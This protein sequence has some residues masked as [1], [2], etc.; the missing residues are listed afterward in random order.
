[1]K[2]RPNYPKGHSQLIQG[3][4]KSFG[5]EFK[6]DMD[7]IQRC[8]N[9]VEKEITLAKSQVDMQEQL[10]QAMERKEASSGRSKMKS[11]FSRTDNTLEE[12]REL[13]LAKYKRRL[14]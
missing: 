6:P 1:L 5:Q 11:F 2:Y 7:D 12:I 10:L 4:Q 9:Y 8:S 14:R 13:Q 3:F